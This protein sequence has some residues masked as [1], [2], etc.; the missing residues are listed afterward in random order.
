M[1][2]KGIKKER[3]LV[4]DMV[5]CFPEERAEEQVLLFLNERGTESQSF[6]FQGLKQQCLRVAQH[7]VN[8]TTKGDIILL[9][10]EEQEHFVVAFFGCILAGCVPAPLPPIRHKRDRTSV[11]RAL[12]VLQSGKANT[13]L[14]TLDQKSICDTITK[15]IISPVK[16]LS[17]EPMYEK[18][19]DR[20]ILPDVSPEDLAY[21]QYTSGS[22]A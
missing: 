14:V 12:R 9:P 3:I 19:R 4:Q 8:E 13:I 20:V 10:I 21:V 7:L 17:L 2:M 6:T 5:M 18:A 1:Y 16:V 22:T 15:E 11:E